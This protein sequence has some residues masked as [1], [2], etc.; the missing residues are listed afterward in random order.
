[1]QVDAPGPLVVFK[2]SISKG[3]GGK[4]ERCSECGEKR[5][6]KGREGRGVGGTYRGIWSTQ[7]FWHGAAMAITVSS[8]SD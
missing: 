1:M 7:K 3:R 4:G 8:V 2:G 6:V 5:K